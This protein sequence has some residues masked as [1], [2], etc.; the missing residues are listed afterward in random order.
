[1][2]TAIQSVSAVNA[3][4]GFRLGRRQSLHQS[5][6]WCSHDRDEVQHRSSS[7]SKRRLRN[8]LAT[9]PEIQRLRGRHKGGLTGHHLHPGA[10]TGLAGPRYTARWSPRQRPRAGRVPA[11]FVTFSLF[12]SIMHFDQYS[13]TSVNCT[14][15]RQRGG[16]HLA[17]DVRLSS[18]GL[19]I[20]I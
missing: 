6:R 7:L 12:L 8:C 11:G 5:M 16:V 18:Y 14:P 9:R 13:V 4:V 15:Q 20:A 3:A 1:M 19:L 2:H 10:K 17:A